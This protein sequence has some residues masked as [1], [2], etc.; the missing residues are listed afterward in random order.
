MERKEYIELC[1]RIAVLP[2]TSGGVP[3]NIPPKLIV[4]YDGIA[5]YPYAFEIIFNK[6]GTYQDRAILHDLKANSIIHCNLERVTR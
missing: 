5:Y 4:N 6:D 2:V 3:A 1:Q